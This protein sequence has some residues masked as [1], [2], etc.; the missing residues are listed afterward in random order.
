MVRIRIRALP[1]TKCMTVEMCRIEDEAE[2]REEAGRGKEGDRKKGDL[3]FLNLALYVPKGNTVGL[4]VHNILL[5]GLSF[6]GLNDCT[7][8]LPTLRT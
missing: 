3:T 2:I 4:C 7:C 8:M 1:C 5:M 6:Y